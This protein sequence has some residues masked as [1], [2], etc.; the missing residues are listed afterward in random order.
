MNYKAYEIAGTDYVVVDHEGYRYLMTRQGENAAHGRMVLEDPDGVPAD[1]LLATLRVMLFKPDPADVLNVGL[2]T[3]MHAKFFH[4]FMRKT[5]VVAV[6]IDPEI[7][8]VAHRYFFLPPDDERLTIVIDDGARYLARQSDRY[9]LIFSDCFDNTF[10]MIDSLADEPYYRS[11][12]QALRNDGILCINV[13][14]RD[15]DWQKW[16]LA[17]LHS[18]FAAVLVVAVSHEQNVVMAFKS[19]PELD[20]DVLAARARALEPGLQ[21]GLPDFVDQ[22]P[23]LLNLQSPIHAAAP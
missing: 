21:L 7:V 20:L 5:R 19:A 1:Y 9:D 3:G 23:A 18:L 13:F 12:R 17:L 11:C 22:L 16:H 14:R 15:A 6:E 4:R 2:G 8:A 10:S